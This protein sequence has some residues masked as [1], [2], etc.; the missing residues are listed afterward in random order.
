MRNGSSKRRIAQALKRRNEQREAQRYGAQGSHNT[1]RSWWNFFFGPCFKY[2]P[3]IGLAGQ[4]R[5]YQNQADAEHQRNERSSARAT[6]AIARL[7]YVLAGVAAIGAIVSYRTLLAIEGQLAEMRSSGDDAKNLIAA[8]K[9][10]AEAAKKQAEAAVESASTARQTMLSG[11]RAWIGPVDARLE[12]EIKQDGELKVVVTYQNSGKEP[13]YNFVEDIKDVTYTKTDDNN[14]IVSEQL[15]L[16]AAACMQREGPRE[17]Q[18][19]FP[20]TGF[21]SYELRIEIDKSHIDDAIV[22]GEN[23][24]FINGCLAYRSFGEFHHEAYPVVPGSTKCGMPV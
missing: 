1:P 22:N 17:A 8:T 3:N 23:T 18:V 15:G 5:T 20:S 10:Q 4:K 6:V 24:L 11:Q 2:T 16:D 13:G 7:T 21:A 9:I 14:G 12:G 19:V